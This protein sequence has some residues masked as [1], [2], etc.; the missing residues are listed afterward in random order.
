MSAGRRFFSFFLA[1]AEVLGSA[2]GQGGACREKM[3]VKTR[4]S[5]KRGGS[6]TKGVQGG[7][8]EVRQ[9]DAP[10]VGYHQTPVWKRDTEGGQRRT[11]K[12]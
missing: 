9:L 10:K 8:Q 6:Q 11:N 7:G 2:P 4:G 5:K 3:R 12:G 1:P